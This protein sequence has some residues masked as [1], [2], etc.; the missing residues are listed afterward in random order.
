[1][2]L[3]LGPK[4]ELFKDLA[5]C[6]D[7]TRRYG[8]FGKHFMKHNQLKEDYTDKLCD[9]ATILILRYFHILKRLIHGHHFKLWLAMYLNAAARCLY[10]QIDDICNTE[11]DSSVT[12]AERKRKR[13]LLNCDTYRSTKV[14]CHGSDAGFMNG[15]R[16]ELKQ[17]VLRCL[18]NAGISERADIIMR[19]GQC[20]AALIELIKDSA[21]A[22]NAVLIGSG[23]ARLFAVNETEQYQEGTTPSLF[24]SPL[25]RQCS[26][27]IDTFWLVEGMGNA[28][29]Y[30]VN[31]NVLD[32]NLKHEMSNDKDHVRKKFS[33]WVREIDRL[34]LDPVS[35]LQDGMEYNSHFKKW[36]E[37]GGILD[38]VASIKE[39]GIFIEVLSFNPNGN[40]NP[41][42]RFFKTVT[43]KLKK[44]WFP[45]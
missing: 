1:M 40:Q 20:K 8:F 3:R 7:G 22:A 17:D 6:V 45:S 9:L 10:W 37:N 23:G 38:P 43:L 34:K 24:L 4:I 31:L 35:L 16:E 26:R 44:F 15:T 36:I 32:R 12:P 30:F 14:I 41:E 39:F 28:E 5:K 11:K 2:K 13:R 27:I 33:D 21:N 42:E 29:Q 18:I 25:L 19:L